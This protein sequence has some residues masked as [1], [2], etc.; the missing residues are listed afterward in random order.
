MAILEKMFIKNTG[1]CAE[2]VVMAITD[3]YKRLLGPTMEIELRMAMK[4]KALCRF[5]RHAAKAAIKRFTKAQKIE[6][7]RRLFI[8]SVLLDRRFGLDYDNIK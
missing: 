8:K 4:K 5:H 3:G 6:P 1:A 7:E 2:Q